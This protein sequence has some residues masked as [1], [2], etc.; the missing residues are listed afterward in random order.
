[1]PI[2]TEF[3]VRLG[4]DEVA[5]VGQKLRGLVALRK[6]QE[7]RA[8]RSDE[9]SDE[10]ASPNRASFLFF[11]SLHSELSSL[12]PIFFSRRTS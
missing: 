11:V 2:A 7:R 6:L 5:A 1:M 9:G 12:S 3:A 10:L 8:E 4:P